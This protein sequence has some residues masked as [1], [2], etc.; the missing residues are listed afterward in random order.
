MSGDRNDWFFA[1]LRRFKVKKS[2]VDS[3]IS[4]CILDN[5]LGDTSLIYSP[6]IEGLLEVTY[7]LALDGLQILVVDHDEDSR[8]LLK[9][10]FAEYGIKTITADSAREALEL[11]EQK[12]PDLLISELL[13]PY[14]DGY[15]LIKA[16][17][18]R[19]LQIPTIALT[20]C[21][22]DHDQSQALA[23]GFCEHLI[24][25][26]DFDN[27]ISMIAYLMPHFAYVLDVTF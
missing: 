7:Y 5:S 8:E 20:V 3:C 18:T 13:L 19:S 12:R 14:E 15:S 16:L 1:I 25:L 24:K 6:V 9:I 11:V 26:F 4:D 23:A 2:S 27:L 10:L 17:K 22:S 21:A